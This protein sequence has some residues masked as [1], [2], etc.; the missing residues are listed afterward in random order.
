LQSL[1]CKLKNRTSLFVNIADMP[2]QLIRAFALF[3]S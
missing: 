2:E 1:R 3:Y